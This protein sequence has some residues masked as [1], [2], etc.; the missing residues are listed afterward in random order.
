MAEWELERAGWSDYHPHSETNVV[1]AGEL[2][3]SCDDGPAVTAGAGESVTVPAGAVGRYWA[4]TFARML[5]IYG[6]NPD[7]AET[8]RLEYWEL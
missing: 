8:Q 2:F 4:P 6:P 1:L 3:V 7:A 5:V